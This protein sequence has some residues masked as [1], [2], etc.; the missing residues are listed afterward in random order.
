MYFTKIAEIFSTSVENSHNIC[1]LYL[2]QIFG[3]KL[4]EV[5]Y[6][7][8][9]YSKVAVTVQCS[10]SYAIATR[11]LPKI[12]YFFAKKTLTNFILLK[13]ETYS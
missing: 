13:I 12:V 4:R 9:P 5:K 2:L 7:N 10:S 8:R 3:L 6:F 11:D 1:F